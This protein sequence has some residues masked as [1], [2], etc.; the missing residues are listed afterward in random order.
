MSLIKKILN[1]HYLKPDLSELIVYDASRN[2]F[3]L[4]KDLYLSYKMDEFVYF[5]FTLFNHGIKNF[6]QNYK[7]NFFK[8]FN[9][10][11]VYTSTDNNIGFFKLK[12]LF[13]K[14]FFIADQNGMRDKKFFSSAKKHKEE[15]YAD[16]FFCFGNNEKSRL[17][18]IIKGKIY[19]LG[20]T[21]N[22]SKK[23]KSLKGFKFKNI[24]LVSSNDV[25]RF[26]K[27]VI[28][29]KHLL[30]LKKSLKVKIYFLDRP[31]ASNKNFLLKTLKDCQFEYIL[32]STYNL[33]KFKQN[34]IFLFSH[35]TLGFEYLSTGLRVACF[36]LNFL[37]HFNNRK[38]KNS[39]LF[40]ENSTNKDKIKKLILRVSKLN[41]NQWKKVSKKYSSQFLLYDKDNFMKKKLIKKL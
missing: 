20:N 30:R 33:K 39:G 41:K 19:P 27:D 16:I 8:F 26:K 7:I 6:F 38:Y 24:V 11:I 34:S 4:N 9:P 31:E 21:L 5:F 10:K 35:S 1:F 18:K 17:K 36:N 2:F 32:N 13:P 29:L 28:I 25:K 15:L 40:W 14:I 12:S 37:E 22:N 23:L 3:F